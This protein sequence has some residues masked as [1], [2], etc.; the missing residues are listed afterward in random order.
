MLL[1]LKNHKKWAAFCD[2]R[3]CLGG[4]EGVWWARIP[5]IRFKSDYSR[6]FSATINKVLYLHAWVMSLWQSE[7]FYGRT[8][9]FS[10]G[11]WGSWLEFR[12]Q[13]RKPGNVQISEATS[14]A[15][16]R[17]TQ[18]TSAT[19]NHT[20][21][22]ELETGNAKKQRI[23]PRNM[24]GSSR[25]AVFTLSTPTRCP[26]YLHEHLRCKIPSCAEGHHLA[27]NCKAGTCGVCPVCRVCR[28]SLGS[29]RRLPVT[30]ARQRSA[31]LA[32]GRSLE[33]DCAASQRVPK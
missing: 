8:S 29:R 20:L 14:D 27:A 19:V 12:A 9:S 21:E 13:R 32:P 15:F 22:L 17:A 26:W 1:V 5:Q 11:L 24:T 18:A 4:S 23:L 6:S 7:G 28:V 3:H 30:K 31:S 25:F 2:W 10:V 16:K 33:V